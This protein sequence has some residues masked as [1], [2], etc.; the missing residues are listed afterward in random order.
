VELINSKCGIPPKI[1]N[2]CPLKNCEHVGQTLD[3]ELTICA[4]RQSS[5]CTLKVNVVLTSDVK[6][7]FRCEA[8]ASYLPFTVI[9]HSTF[10]TPCFWK[11]LQVHLRRWGGSNIAAISQL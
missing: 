9:S 6:F 3:Q 7:T 1:V 8:P 11:R 2:I 5:K 4:K 10:A